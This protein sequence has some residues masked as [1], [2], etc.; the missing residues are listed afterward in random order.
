MKDAASSVRGC[1]ASHDSGEDVSPCGYL[2]EKEA[3]LQVPGV[4]LL[5]LT[6]RK[7]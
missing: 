2:G 5:E 3:L 4:S 6:A 7:Y 1:P